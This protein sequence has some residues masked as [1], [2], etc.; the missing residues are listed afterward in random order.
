MGTVFQRGEAR[1]R[2]SFQTMKLSSCSSALPPSFPTV[3]GPVS[4]V[5]CQPQK[6]VS[7]CTLAA[8]ARLPGTSVFLTITDCP[9][10]SMGSDYVTSFQLHQISSLAK[11][12]WVMETD[13]GQSAKAGPGRNS[14]LTVLGGFR[15][16][17]SGPLPQKAKCIQTRRDK[18]IPKCSYSCWAPQSKGQ[19]DQRSQRCVRPYPVSTNKFWNFQSYLIEL[20]S[21]FIFSFLG[22]FW[23]MHWYHTMCI[24]V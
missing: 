16:L 6:M 19:G 5:T 8:A 2:E 23:Y 18:Q 3:S 7:G 17:S 11:A 14:A 12:V 22:L 24:I 21:P 20:Y 10:T 15:E 1:P 4:R 9:L 13:P